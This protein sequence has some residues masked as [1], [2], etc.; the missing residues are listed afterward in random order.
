MTSWKASRRTVLRMAGLT[1]TGLS[2]GALGAQALAQGSAATAPLRKLKVAWSQSSACHAPLAFGQQT[3]IFAKYGLDVELLNFSASHTE[4]LTLI[5]TGKADAGIGLLQGWLK[6]LEQGFD[7]KLV[8]GTHGGCLRLLTS[9]DSGITEISHLKGK[10]IAVAALT[11]PAKEAFVVTLARAGLDP[12]RDVTWSVFPG[13]LLE[14]AV[15]KGQ[16]QAIAHY[17]PEA[18]RFRKHGFVEI[19][20]N[21]TGDYANRVCCVVGA[22]AK[23][24]EKDKPLVRALVQAVDEVHQ[25]TSRYPREIAKYYFD[26]FKPNISL[27]E[28]SEQLESL[29]YHHHPVGADFQKELVLAIDDLKLVRVLKQS[30]DSSAFARQI[31]ADV[32]A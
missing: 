5:A 9:P 4:L 26:T 6:P 20:S 32:F 16:A 10:T 18:F 15:Q 17:D 8:A 2:L 12:E 19:A 22:T 3:G 23:L 30:T 31:S 25:Y 13:D 29:A 27:E 1:A 14:L 24:L 28:L 7:V 11:S 21:Q